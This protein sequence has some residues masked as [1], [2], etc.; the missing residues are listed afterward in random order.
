M[1]HF[2]FLLLASALFMGVSFTSCL[3]SD[4]D[5]YSY[6]GGIAKMQ[7]SFMSGTYYFKMADGRLVYPTEASINSVKSLMASGA[8]EKLD[9][10]IV[11]VAWRWDESLLQIADD[12]Q[13]IQGVELY[14]IESLDNPVGIVAAQNIGKENLDSIKNPAPIIG[15]ETE[16]GN[17]KYFPYFLKDDN[18]AVVLPI[19]Y[20][21]NS[22][23]HY[24]SLI[25]YD[26]STL[27]ADAVNMPEEVTATLADKEQGIL[28]LY[29]R[30]NHNGDYG[31]NDDLVVANGQTS[32]ELASYGLYG[33]GNFYKGYDLSTIIYRYWYPNEPQ[34]VK[35]V[36]TTN[37]YNVDMSDT[38]QEEQEFFVSSWEDVDAAN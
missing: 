38:R 6:D 5:P 29:L 21:I 33:I 13:D 14:G 27:S 36:A 34:Q 35:I 11:N 23:F 1:R 8:F 20:F 28:R 26:G 31:V 10:K 12:A 24:L 37:E 25:Y 30:H 17:Y 16:I 2:K 4:S 15:L 19:N 9:G 18:S 7:S 22:K 3:D 32:Y